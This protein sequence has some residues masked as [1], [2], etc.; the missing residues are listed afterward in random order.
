MDLAFFHI[1]EDLA[2][3]DLFCMSAKASFWQTGINIIQISDELTPAS[4]HVDAV[5]RLKNLKCSMFDRMKAYR[6][7]LR[8]HKKP[9][10]FF[11]T[12][13]LII[14]RFQLDFTIGP[15]LC[16]RHFYRKENIVSDSTITLN[17][18]TL[19]YPENRSKQREDIYPYVGCFFADKNSKFLDK[20]I[21]IY[22]KLPE[23]YMYR[24]GDQV[25]LRE[26]ALT[27]SICRVNE[28]LIACLP[29]FYPS[30]CPDA[31]ALHFKGDKR[32]N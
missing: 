20:A 29:E 23:K 18:Q 27:S 3:P 25:A 22:E 11:D 8:V 31:V 32:K 28:A 16:Q 5:Y 13:I 6:G 10:A 26:A 30:G 2:L 7:L 12:D 9:I 21:N 17:K 1:G 24:H 19:S 4:K 14:K 15:A